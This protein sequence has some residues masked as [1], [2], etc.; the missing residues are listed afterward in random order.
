MQDYNIQQTVAEMKLLDSFGGRY[1]ERRF[2]DVTGIEQRELATAEM[3]H[4]I[5][6]RIEKELDGARVSVT[7]RDKRT[8]NEK[9]VFFDKVAIQWSK[10]LTPP[11]K[12]DTEKN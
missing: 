7:M 3:K 1:F 12:N 2:C 4:T 5:K 6:Q 10:P 9:N 11:V 8:D